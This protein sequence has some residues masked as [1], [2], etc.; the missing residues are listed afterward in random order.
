MEEKIQKVI[1]GSMTIQELI[2]DIN[3]QEPDPARRAQLMNE[4][5][6]ALNRIN[7]YTR[8]ETSA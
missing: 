3:A 8:D 4:L 1:D 6:A 5:W 2:S 7:N